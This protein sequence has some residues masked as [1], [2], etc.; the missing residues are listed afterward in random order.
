[1]AWVIAVACIQS[2]AQEVLHA[3]VMAR[4]KKCQEL[5]SVP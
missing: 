5:F 1:M 4:K 2:L 3:K